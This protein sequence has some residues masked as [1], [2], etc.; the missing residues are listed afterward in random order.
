MNTAQ[1]QL[2]QDNTLALSGMLNVTTVTRLWEQSQSLLARAATPLCIDLKAVSE[3]DSAG[4]ALLIAWV[5]DLRAQHKTLQ[6]V[7]LPE[8]MRAIMHVSG[9]DT[10]LPIQ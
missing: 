3:S 10:I 2:I 4:V 7:H 9:L 8:Q 1:I 5:R 6:F